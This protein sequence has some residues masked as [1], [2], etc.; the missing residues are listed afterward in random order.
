MPFSNAPYSS[1]TIAL[2]TA[3]LETAWMAARLGVP[4]LSHVDRADMERAILNAAAL[5]ERDFRQLQQQ[6]I[7]AVG[8]TGVKPIERR[9]RPRLVAPPTDEDSED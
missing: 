9:Q 8:A 6:A 1:D 3:A 2:M 5:G 4:D 7:D